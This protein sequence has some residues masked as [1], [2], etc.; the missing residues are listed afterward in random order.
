MPRRDAAIIAILLVSTFVV[1]LNETIMGIALPVLTADLHVDFA[2]GQWLTS[3]F[4]LTMAVVIPVTGFLIRRV[5]TRRLF[6]VAMALFSAGTLLAATAPVF[7]V[8]LAARVVQASGTAIMMPLLMTTVMKLVPPQ[9]RGAVMGN[10]GTVIAVAPAI[11]PTISGFVLHSLSWRFMFWL[12][13]PVALTALVVG[14]RRI[15][16]VGEPEHVRIDPPSVILSAFGFG[17]LVYGLSSLGHEGTG[18]SPSWAPIVVGVTALALFVGRQRRLQRTDTALLDL[19]TFRSGGFTIALL[20][21]MLSMT[22]LFGMVI[23]LPIYMQTVIGLDTRTAGLLLLPGGLMMGLLG[24]VVGRQYDRLGARPLVVPGMVLTS[25][26]LWSATLFTSDTGIPMLMTFHIMLA[27]GLAL[28]FT[29]LFTAGL[30]SVAPR[31]YSYGSAIFGT[32]QQLA[33]ATGVA[34]LVSV[35][36]ARSSSLAAAGTVP[37]EAAAGGI[38]AAY[39]VAATLSLIGIVG[40]FFVRTPVTSESTPER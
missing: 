40:A 21:M 20:L 23:L 1:I 27:V 3:G 17:G 13:L 38:H 10:I 30:G 24:P 19:R 33:G 35:M 15:V 2:A 4:L 14:S 11:G 34:L 9:R 25:L 32:G 28:V 31:N 12:V 26:A 37:V 22:T 29:P 7:G 16:D 5:R 36:T 8:L 39:L 6:C 18:A